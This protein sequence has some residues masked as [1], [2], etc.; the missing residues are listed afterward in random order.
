MQN[1]SIFLSA[2]ERE[3]SMLDRLLLTGHCSR[4]LC[5]TRVSTSKPEVLRNYK[6]T[7]PTQENYDCT[8]WEAASATAAA[9][10][11]FKSVTLSSTHDN[12]CDGGMKRTNPIDEIIQEYERIREWNSKEIGCIVSIGTGVPNFRKVEKRLDKLLEACVNIMMDAQDIADRFA[13]S[14]SGRMFADSNRYFRFNVPQG[15]GDIQ[16]D[17]WEDTNK[18][19]DR[20]L[21]YLRAVG[22]GRDI[23]QCAKSLINPD[24]NCQPQGT[25]T[26]SG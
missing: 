23:E 5:V 2:N 12:F 13:G 10:M 21:E 20:T 9:P 7:D 16:L 24:A 11:F 6:A 17:G 22:T 25:V 1:V 15:M 4:L 3:I 14:N 8:I 26:P 18:M 19:R